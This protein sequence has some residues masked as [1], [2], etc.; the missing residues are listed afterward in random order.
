VTPPATTV[1]FSTPPTDAEIQRAR[2]FAEPLVRIVS[3]TMKPTEDRIAENRDLGEVILR[4]SGRGDAN[5]IGEFTEF[6]K[7]YPTS[8][9]RIAV[10][11]NIGIVERQTG[12]FTRAL[13]HWEEAWALG[14][15]VQKPTREAKAV[16][17]RCAAE[18]AELNSRLGRYE[19]L[20]TLLPELAS[21]P[22]DGTAATKVGWAREGFSTMK[23][24]PERAFLCGPLS[25]RS[26]RLLTS[27]KAFGD[28]KIE[29]LKSTMKGTSLA[30]VKGLSDQL[31][32]GYQSAFREPGAPVVFPAVV[33]WKAGHFAALVG[34]TETPFGTR[35]HFQDPTFGDDFWV[36]Q[37]AMD[38]EASGYCLIPAGKLS[39]GWRTV[40]TDEAGTVWGKGV[41]SGYDPNGFSCQFD[42]KAKSG[43]G[44][45]SCGGQSPMMASYNFHAML[46]SLNINDTPVGYAPPV[47]PAVYGSVTYNQFESIQPQSP[48]YGNFGPNWTYQWL[49]FIEDTPN[50]PAAGGRVYLRG[51]GGEKFSNYNSTTQLY[52]S[53]IF[54][55]SSLKLV[56]DNSTQTVYE[57]TLPDGSVETYG[58]RDLN[59]SPRRVFLTKVTDPQGNAVELNYDSQFRLTS[60]KDAGDRY[61]TFSYELSGDPLKITKITDPFNR[62]AVFTYTDGKLTKITDTVGI[63]SA[64]TYSTISTEGAGFIKTLTTPYGTTT[65]E[66]GVTNTN[67][68]PSR[69]LEATDPLGQKERLEFKSQAIPTGLGS[70]APSLGNYFFDGTYIDYR[71]TFYWDKSIYNQSFKDQQNPDYTKARIFHWQHSPDYPQVLSRLLESS[72]NPLEYRQFYVYQGQQQPYYQIGITNATP[73][74]V[75][76][77]MDDG[78]TW[79]TQNTYNPRGKV[80][81][82]IDPVGRETVYEYSSDGID[83]LTMKQR[84]NTTTPA[85]Y[86]TL[87]TYTYN[88]QHLPLTMTD[89]AGKTTT[90]TYNAKGQI[91]TVTN[92]KNET[93][94]YAYNAEGYLVSVTGAQAG[95]TTTYD[96]RLDTN[97]K[98]LYGTVWKVTDSDGYV[99]ATD[100]DNFDRPIKMTYPDATYREMSYV[101]PSDSKVTLS[102]WSVRDRQGRITNTVYDALGRVTSVTDPQNRTTIFGWCI[103][104]GLYK[105]TD[106]RGQETIWNRDV[107]GRVTSKVLQD[108]ATTNFVYEASTGRLKSVTD[109]RGQRTNYV[110][111]KDNN[112]QQVSYTNTAGQPLN[113]VTPTVTYAYDQFYNRMTSMTDG[114]GAT[115]YA[116]HPV[117]TAQLGAGQLAS[118]DG[119]L[120]NDTISFT[121][122]ELGRR[123]TRSIGPSGNVSTMSYDSLGRFTSWSNPL[124]TFTPT[125]DGVTRRLLQ[126]QY[127]NGQ[128]VQLTYASNLG[129]RRLL[130]IHNKDG[131]NATISKFDYTFAP[132]G[133]IT[134]WTRQA[135]S[136]TPQTETFTHDNADQLVGAVLK[137]GA[138]T[139][140][141][142][143]YAYD[144]AGNRTQESL[145]VGNGFPQTTDYQN[146]EWDAASRI[147]AVVKGTRRSEFS[148]DGLGRRVRIVEKQGS[149]VVSDKRYIWDDGGICEERD[150]SSSGNVLKRY[151]GWGVQ[152]GT[153]NY[154]FSADQ[155]SS[156]R[157]VTDT[158]GNVVS[159]FDYDLWGRQSQ[160]SGTYKPDWGFAGTFLHQVSGLGL[161]RYRAYDPNLGRWLSRDP[162]GIKGGFNL[163]TYVR[164]KPI[165]FVD[166]EGL[167]E[168]TISCFLTTILAS[169]A[170]SA[171]GGCIA[172]GLV[173]SLGLAGGPVG[174][175][176]IGGGCVAGALAGAE[177]GAAGGLLLAAAICPSP[178]PTCPTPDNVVPREREEEKTIEDVIPQKPP[179]R[180]WK[181]ETR[182]P[183]RRDGKWVCVYLCPNGQE[184]TRPP[185]SPG[186]NGTCRPWV[187]V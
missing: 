128:K 76:K 156:I 161:T 24:E 111:F 17:D 169:A 164:N 47:G 165:T 49:S 69:Y 48:Q 33:H 23:H 6:L 182:F 35:Y 168:E 135:G 163:Y 147:T 7:R 27:P 11:T 187:D 62:Q 57:R 67:N 61:T 60:I 59:T 52:D 36:S 82:A 26:I 30:Q 180:C 153:T 124:G 12:Y 64:F 123:L 119:P 32:M 72:R 16:I 114:I 170:A 183:N 2:V 77:K 97:G 125:F 138:T 171:L 115:N 132:E 122:D 149:T 38:A 162:I 9:W 28:E 63:E 109:P 136:A 160:V 178:N 87:A 55:Q 43:G 103:C 42:L 146:V 45:S 90:N 84:V 3:P 95:A 93:T 152:E 65:F 80:T 130:T 184:I 106:A 89:A 75:V 81:K 151:L 92:A 112:L 21:R 13:S 41:V 141:Q 177:I 31:K 159:R 99:V 175:A 143:G 127:P 50:N 142:T 5:Q 20:E 18:L 71:N 73:A 104:N 68:L 58:L 129:D 158:N 186:W 101:R 179:M 110:Y 173:G 181:K 176:T 137:E 144:L 150:G 117:S 66:T 40:K 56:A 4:F 116:Y 94:T 70:E 174:L 86:E 172:G 154:F 118:V 107:Q 37:A 155:L 53:Q 15:K 98:V 51:G 29:A 91:L 83:L 78:T 44:C 96:Y 10:L 100:Y 145:T 185:L 139:V 121:Y 54:S 134:T 157:E 14:S 25:I 140:R 102:V 34:K 19:R 120:V 79:A 74:V 108:G 1:S 39:T 22:M 166:P 113:P 148:Y 131:A 8:E 46:V 133:N 167:L 88:S 85:Q 105:M 126:I